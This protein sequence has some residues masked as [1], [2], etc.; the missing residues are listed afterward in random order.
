MF[1]LIVL[2]RVPGSDIEITFLQA[3][4][5]GLVFVY[6]CIRIK[7]PQSSKQPDGSSSKDNS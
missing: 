2:G 5:T 3:L 6:A 1:E 7:D 4:L